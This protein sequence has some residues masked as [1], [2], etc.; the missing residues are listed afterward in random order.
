MLTK[1]KSFEAVTHQCFSMNTESND[2]GIC[3]EDIEEVPD[4]FHQYSVAT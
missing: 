1:K 3:E 2:C 4:C